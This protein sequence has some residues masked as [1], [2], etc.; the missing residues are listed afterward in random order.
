MSFDHRQLDAPAYTYY[1]DPR[2]RDRMRLDGMDPDQS[3]EEAIAA[4]QRR[5]LEL[6]ADTARKVWG[7][8][9]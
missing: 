6:V 3:L 2:L 7:G 8:R 4:E 9:L 1:A 5:K